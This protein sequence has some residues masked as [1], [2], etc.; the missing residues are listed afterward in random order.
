[1]IGLDKNKNRKI[2]K[3]LK[4]NVNLHLI[5]WKKSKEYLD[6]LIATATFELSS[7]GTTTASEG[8]DEG[9]IQ[10]KVYEKK[11]KKCRP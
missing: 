3:Y 4:S 10:F 8:E 7:S 6:K 1:M 5:I 11:K 2:Q 9:S